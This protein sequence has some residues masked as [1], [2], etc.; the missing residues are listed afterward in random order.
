MAESAGT[1]GEIL[2][3]TEVRVELTDSPD[4]LVT[5][6]A[7]KAAVPMGMHDELASFFGA[8]GA[9]PRPSTLDYV[10]GA[11]AAC[12]A[13][14]FRRALAARGVSIEPQQLGTE[15]TGL[16]V[17]KDRVPMIEAVEVRYRLRGTRPEDRTRIER[18]HAVHH[19]ACAVSRSLEG[20]FEVSTSLEIEEVEA[21][22]AVPNDT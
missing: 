10:V 5:L 1:T 18:A 20:A 3:R 17:V 14:T 9:T 15:A 2:M 12:L 13:G 7:E 11:L 4:K 21:T 19:R 16:I 8:E 22:E 6:P